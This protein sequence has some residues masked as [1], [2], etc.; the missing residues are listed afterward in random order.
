[1]CSWLG[2][3]HDDRISYKLVNGMSFG[4][5]QMPLSTLEPASSSACVV[6]K[7]PAWEP[8][9]SPSSSAHL[10]PA[11]DPSS[12]TPLLSRSASPV[13]PRPVHWLDDPLVWSW[14][15]KLKVNDSTPGSPYVEF[16][17]VENDLVKVRDKADVK[18][19]TLES[20]SPLSPTMKGDLV[21]LK[22]G[23]MQGT[24]FNII[25]VAGDICS[26][27]KPGVR[28]TKKNPDTEYATSDL[29]QIYPPAC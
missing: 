10:S 8:S 13:P 20:I 12:R 4:N 19:F 5:V 11:W 18:F 26:V 28:L 25:R 23:D 17:G 16:L 6:G 22:A 15:I 3:T 21:I 14:R 7:T 1:M 2:R 24:A 27:C 9:D 29:V